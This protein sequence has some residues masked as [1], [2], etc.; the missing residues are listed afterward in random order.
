MLKEEVN[1]LDVNIKLI[2]GELKT[3]LFVK[4][5]DTHQFLDPTSCHPYHCKK[6]IPYSQALRFNRICS[7]NETFDRRCNNLEKWLMKRGCNEKMI[8]KQILS[9]RE[10]SRNGLLEKEKQQWSERK[11]TFNLLPSFS[12]Y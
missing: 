5:T 10:H 4:P 9:A 6:T 11:L 7:D 8:R 2:D 12:K 1:F 3:D